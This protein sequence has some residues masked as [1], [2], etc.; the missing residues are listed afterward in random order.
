MPTSFFP[1]HDLNATTITEEYGL[2]P[3]LH[4]KICLTIFSNDGNELKKSKF[5][6]IKF[7]SQKTLFSIKW[8]SSYEYGQDRGEKI[9]AL[10]RKA[11]GRGLT[12]EKKFMQNLKKINYH[13]FIK[14]NNFLSPNLS[15]A[16]IFSETKILKTWNLI[17]FPYI[18]VGS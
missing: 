3:I 9:Q 5:S 15:R 18:V 2:K 14:M 1:W 8:R 11:V 13:Y 6:K 10:Q 16:K 7:K 17:I 12:R 4:F